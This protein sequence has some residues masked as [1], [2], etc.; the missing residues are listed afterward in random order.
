MSHITF[1]RSLFL[2]F[3]AA[4]VL[5]TELGAARLWD[6][7]EPRN[8]RASHE[9]LS[10]GDWIVPTFNGELRDHKPILLY[11]LQ[12]LSFKTLG[13]SE[14]TA[15]LPSA[16]C[17]V[18]T[19][20][21]VAILASRLA[22][23]PRG[24]SHE[25][26]WAAGAL[27]TCMFFVLAGRAATPDSCLIAF[28]TL[29][30]AAIVLSALAPSRPFSSGHVRSA[31]WLPAML[32]YA[33]LGVAGLAKGPV[34]ILLPLAV[35]HIWWMVC[36]WLQQE[37]SRA[38]ESANR[39]ARSRFLTLVHR[40]W[41][42]FHPLQCL[43][44]IWA[45]RT[46]PGLIVTL[47]V[48]APW[49]YAVGVATNGE[50]LR[51]FFL[52]HNV[53]RAMTT[54]EGHGGTLLYYP[55][56]F[57]I[58]TFPWS[59]W[60]I[61]IVIWSRQA[62]RQGVVQRQMVVLAAAWIGVYVAAFSLAGTKLPSYITPCYAGAA[63][64]IGGYL[65]HFEL[66]WSLPSRQL[67]NWAYVLTCVIGLVIG[68]AVIALSS[69]QSMPLLMRAAFAGL[70]IAVIGV[71]G[72]L[73]DRAQLTGRVPT[74]WL[75][76]AAV[77]QIVLF[78]FG[79]KSVDQYRQDLAM[80]DQV[81]VENNVE[82]WI[83]V[84]GLEPSWVHYLGATVLEVPGSPSDRATWTEIERQFEKYPKTKLIVVGDADLTTLPNT[85]IA[86]AIQL[87]QI[88]IAPQFLKS[89]FVAV[90]GLSPAT[91]DINAHPEQSLAAQDSSPS[92][93]LGASPLENSPLDH[94]LLDNPNQTKEVGHVEL[95]LS[96]LP[97]LAAESVSPVAPISELEIP[98]SMDVPSLSF[99]L[100]E[101]S[102]PRVTTSP[103]AASDKEIP[104]FVGP[105][106]MDTSQPSHTAKFPNPLRPTTPPIDLPDSLR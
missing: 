1:R 104:R 59:L 75:I 61:P 12:M 23:H 91:S 62:S 55:V 96:S 10:R 73:W 53:S 74:T 19:I 33:A 47:L 88:A 17:A 15:R 37:D 93:R 72:F 26:Y 41:A 56:A 77:Y 82:R 35:V 68:G 83:S 103:N 54:M 32:G 58:G 90:Y 76:G 2:L 22:G 28:S 40:T 99:M 65:R 36:Y 43:T 81:V 98:S 18:L 49:Y 4:G 38:V 8:T 52:D 106:P 34:G 79:T 24:I 48:A 86:S 31:K 94:P 14:F 7:D 42:V 25:G 66:G 69:A 63:L 44:A 6:R 16:L 3:I 78:G 97:D 100:P 102:D 11:W 46:V 57:V 87:E 80:F 29:G 60:L 45:L 5:F 71:I 21:A 20:L 84:G 92:D 50:F 30:I 101:Q 105:S 67:R 85:S 13:E 64:V 27:A 51:G 9:M 70:A 39:I 89:G 95:R